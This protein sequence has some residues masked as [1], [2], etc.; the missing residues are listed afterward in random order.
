MVFNAEIALANHYPSYNG[1]IHWNVFNCSHKLE[2]R[3]YHQ[4]FPEYYG[5]PFS[6]SSH[7]ADEKGLYYLADIPLSRLIQMRLA[8][9]QFS[10]LHPDISKKNR[11]GQ[12]IMTKFS[13]NTRLRTE[14]ILKNYQAEIYTEPD[15]EEVKKQQ[16]QFIQELYNSNPIMSNIVFMYKR[17]HSDISHKTS[18]GKTIIQNMGIRLKETKLNFSAGFFSSEKAFSF[19]RQSSIS[20]NGYI[21]TEGEGYL[22]CV[23]IKQSINKNINFLYNY[24]YHNSTDSE[25]IH[26]LIL[27]ISF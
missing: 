20:Q 9:D 24:N 10:C 26:R 11:N 1:S 25:E 27:N 21:D 4:Y 18:Y 17:E 6:R 8:I 12:E 5:N 14:L 22:F 13:L 7:F 16:V 3:Q 15:W 2:Y 19:Y 23:D